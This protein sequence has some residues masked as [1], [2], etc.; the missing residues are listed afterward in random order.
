MLEYLRQAD[1]P[2]LPLIA[3]PHPAAK[4]RLG[5]PHFEREILAAMIK[6]ARATR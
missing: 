2:A 1:S 3:A 4:A 5:R 6:A